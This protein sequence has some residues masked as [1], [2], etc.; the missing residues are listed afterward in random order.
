MA[1]QT[2][3]LSRLALAA[4]VGIICLFA[5]ENLSFA[6]QFSPVAYADAR[7]ANP[8]VPG[9]AA[10]VTRRT[11]RAAAIG[12]EVVRAGVFYCA[13]DVHYIPGGYWAPGPCYYGTLAPVP[14]IAPGY[15][16]GPYPHSVTVTPMIGRWC[17]G[18]HWC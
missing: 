9:N 14:Y 3:N 5:D 18:W 15:L 12:G 8:P 6:K 1:I 11:R 4:A 2:S 7:V 17:G 10:R 16:P 13:S